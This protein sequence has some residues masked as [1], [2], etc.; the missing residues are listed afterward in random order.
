MLDTS[1]SKPSKYPFLILIPMPARLDLRPKRSRQ[2]EGDLDQAI[3]LLAK[4]GTMEATRQDAL[5]W[6]DKAKTA[7]D[8]VPDHPLKKMLVDLAD[9]VVAR[10]T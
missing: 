10:I 9:Y 3:A 4:H 2:E 6:A 8:A 5:A 1:S 7:L